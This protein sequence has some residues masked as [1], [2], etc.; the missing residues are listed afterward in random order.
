MNSTE[1]TGSLMFFTIGAVLI[2]AIATFV[3]FLRKPK[4]RKS[5]PDEHPLGGDWKANNEK[6]DQTL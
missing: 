6:V 5:L 4:N 3:W 1:M 2:I